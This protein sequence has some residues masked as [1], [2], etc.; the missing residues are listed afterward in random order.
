MKRGAMVDRGW[1]D[2]ASQLHERHEASDFDSKTADKLT[3]ES[4]VDTAAAAAERDLTFRK[5]S[6]Y[7]R[8]G[9]WGIREFTHLRRI[10]ARHR[11]RQSPCDAAGLRC[12][13]RRP[14]S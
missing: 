14:G 3:A 5:R 10:A 11:S 9:P 2:L 7:G 1:G 12:G 8:G 6:L 13:G 4:G